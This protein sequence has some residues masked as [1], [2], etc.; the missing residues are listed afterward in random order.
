M[1]TYEYM[2]E[3]CNHEW[4]EYH[5]IT[6]DPTKVCPECGKESAKRLISGGSGKGVVTLYGGELKAKIKDDAKK[7]SRDAKTKESVYANLLGNDKY[8]EI[9]SR[10]DKNKPERNEALKSFKRKK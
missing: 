6:R 7:L 10:M 8:Q 3:E 5:E 9:Q 4:E 2:C 1:P